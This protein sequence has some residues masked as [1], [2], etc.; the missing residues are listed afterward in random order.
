MPIIGYPDK[1]IEEMRKALIIGSLLID[2]EYYKSKL[3]ETAD[4]LGDLLSAKEATD[5]LS[6]L[7][8]KERI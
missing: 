3:E 1:K 6:G 8:N 7:M 2:Q 5:F 4:F